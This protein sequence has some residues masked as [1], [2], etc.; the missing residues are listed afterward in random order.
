MAAATQGNLALPPVRIIAQ[1][2]PQA[3]SRGSLRR[4]WRSAITEPLLRASLSMSTPRASL[5]ATVSF[6]KLSHRLREVKMSATT[7]PVDTAA[8]LGNFLAGQVLCP[9][10][11][12]YEEARR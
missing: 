9:A 12:G 3:A 11:A 2:W 8:E 7:S 10:D 6:T 1:S 5:D 4:K